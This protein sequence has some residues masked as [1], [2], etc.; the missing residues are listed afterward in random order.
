MS[1]KATV[2]IIPHI[3]FIIYLKVNPSHYSQQI[4]EFRFEY[5]LIIS[6]NFI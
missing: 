6:L 4:L 1:N 3:E 2:G 5:T